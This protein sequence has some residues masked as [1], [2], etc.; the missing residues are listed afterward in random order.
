M[1]QS[2]RLAHH[3]SVC[4][5]SGNLKALKNGSS[6]DDVQ[7]QILRNRAVQNASRLARSS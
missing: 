2:T 3:W 7:E 1:P 5:L 6:V 4:I